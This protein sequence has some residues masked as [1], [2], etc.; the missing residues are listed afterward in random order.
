[1]LTLVIIAKMILGFVVGIGSA[2]LMFLAAFAVAYFILQIA[3]LIGSVV[4]WLNLRN[5]LKNAF[6]TFF[7]RYLY[8]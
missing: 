8:L 2:V 3:M 7:W 1:M 4:K 6:G 5:F